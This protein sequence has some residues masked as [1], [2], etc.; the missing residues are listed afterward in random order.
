MASLI[1]NNIPARSSDQIV[2]DNDNFIIPQDDQT[3][4]DLM[5]KLLF[6]ED[7]KTRR[8]S[9]SI[10]D[11]FFG[12]ALKSPFLSSKSFF[13]SGAP[14]S[15][16]SK[17]SSRMLNPMEKHSL[18]GDDTSR[19]TSSSLVEE[20]LGEVSN[21]SLHGEKVWIKSE[22][23]EFIAASS[24]AYDQEP[25][26][27]FDIASTMYDSIIMTN[28]GASLEPMDDGRS[29]SNSSTVL[30]SDSLW[31]DL[32]MLE[33]P[34]SCSASR[35]TTCRS[36]QSS[37]GRQDHLPIKS[38]P[39]DYES[40]LSCQFGLSESSTF[41]NTTTSQSGSRDSFLFD[42]NS[43]DSYRIPSGASNTTA[44]STYNRP[45]LSSKSTFNQPLTTDITTSKQI[46]IQH[47][48]ANS[49][50]LVCQAP[51]SGFISPK[52]YSSSTIFTSSSAPH[53]V[54]S[55]FLPP[56]PPTSQPAS[57]NNEGVRRTPPPPYPGNSSQIR[58]CGLSPAP[59]SLPLTVTMTSQ[60]KPER[61]R[62][63]PVTHPGCSTI[64]YNRKNNPELEKRRIH[65]CVF[66]GC[67][68]AYTKSSHLKAHQRIHTGEKPYKCHI[69]TCGWRFARS[70]E[71][72]RH[73]RK[74]TGAKPFICKVCERSFARSDHLALH[75]KRHE[76]KNK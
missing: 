18:F 26:E 7:T 39:V 13:L 71:L 61:P 35:A 21:G 52:P 54:P 70:D 34:A 23:P 16:A 63:Q 76:P 9:A 58:T 22:P 3:V 51:T 57:P 43:T 32:N 66:P 72:T 64:K 40:M 20:F 56:T 38:E 65:F 37:S 60:A 53:V 74:H 28:G 73:I 10:I 12:D 30:V 5:D 48:S 45:I 42:M 27:V 47:S 15:N 50:G 4:S 69:Q 17:L 1:H 33:N 8:E 25:A 62:K 11:D 14:C 68:K 49:G 55:M 75:M 31:E 24:E 19:R 67:R 6:T 46:I 36:I 59:S 41:H 2:P 44:I 29:T